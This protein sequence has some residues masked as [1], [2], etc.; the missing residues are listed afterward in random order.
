M[1]KINN[2]IIICCR[3]SYLNVCSNSHIPVVKLLN[4]SSKKN[5]AEMNITPVMHN[6]IS[7]IGCKFLKFNAIVIPDRKMN[8]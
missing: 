7:L 4:N 1:P 5:K 2:F 6:I 8:N 3:K